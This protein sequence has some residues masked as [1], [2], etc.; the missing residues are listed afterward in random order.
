LGYACI[1]Y[2]QLSSLLVLQKRYS[3]TH[4]AELQI[5][6]QIFLSLKIFFCFTRCQYIYTNQIPTYFELQ[7]CSKEPLFNLLF[8]VL[9]LPR[10]T[11]Y[12]N[13]I[14]NWLKRHW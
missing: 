12:H 13:Q 5:L 6:F 11:F 14:L 3:S 2:G 1:K 8:V 10:V 7:T 4:V 9:L